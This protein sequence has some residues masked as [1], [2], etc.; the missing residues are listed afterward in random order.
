LK[1]GRAGSNKTDDEEEKRAGE[2]HKTVALDSR[3]QAFAQFLDV[4]PQGQFSTAGEPGS[5]AESTKL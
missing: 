1:Q 5:T 3:L 4:A 2:Q